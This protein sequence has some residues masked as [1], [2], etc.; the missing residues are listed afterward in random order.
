[1]SDSFIQLFRT[2]WMKYRN[3][4][5][6]EICNFS[7]SGAQQCSEIQEK[8]PMAPLFS[9]VFQAM[10]QLACDPD[11]V[12]RQLFLTLSYQA[13]HWF[14]N[15]QNFENPDTI[16]LLDAI[17]VRLYHPFAKYLSYVSFAE[18]GSHFIDIYI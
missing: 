7:L 13:I 3:I 10:L 16:V 6:L 9:H 18:Q 14:T 8:Y 17:M 1:M 5:Y 15:N 2:L 11:Q 12:T 4:D